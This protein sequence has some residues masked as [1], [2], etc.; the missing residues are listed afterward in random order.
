MGGLGD[1]R[2]ANILHILP[3]AAATVNG[4]FK[5]YVRIRKQ[6][7]LSC[8]AMRYTIP[9]NNMRNPRPTH[10][11]L[12]SPWRTLAS[13]EK[14]HNPWLVV[15]EHQTVRPDGQMGIYGI[16]DP[17]DNVTMVAL[18]DQG[19]VLLVR[20]F[21]YP[22][23]AWA[24]SLPSGAVAAGEE[25]RAAAARELAEEGGVAAAEWQDLGTYWLS[26]GISP[27]TSFL[28]LARGLQT[29]PAHPE[30]TEVLTRRWLPLAAALRAARAGTIRH[31]VAALAL[32]RAQE[33]L[34]PTEIVP[35][36]NGRDIV[37]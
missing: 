22:V 10:D 9:M 3:P 7:I 6:A 25:P 21:I 13:A 15:T 30:P 31:A 12:G 11:A 28:F 17:G 35:P 33:L 32:L 16:V 8:P 37:Q 4:I 36:R 1:P 26:P 27:Q 23:Q 34:A 14:Y 29:V 5:L 20:D 19:Q 2:R 24:W 18:D